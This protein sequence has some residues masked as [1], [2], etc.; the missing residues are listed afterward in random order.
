[1]STAQ[2]PTTDHS[3]C[4]WYFG[5]FDQKSTAMTRRP[6][7]A[8]NRMAAT[9]P[10]SITFTMGVLYVATTSSYA[11]GDTLTSEVSRTCTNRKKKMRTPVTR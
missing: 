10:Y 4:R 11:S 1:M 8:W 2:I 3:I 6:L 5:P 7:R 9:R